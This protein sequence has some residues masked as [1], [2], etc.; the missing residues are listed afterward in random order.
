MWFC[1][2]SMMCVFVWGVCLCYVDKPLYGCPLLL[3]WEGKKVKRTFVQALR[4]CIGRTAYRGSRGIALPFLDYGTRRGWAVIVTLRPLFTPGKTRYPIC[5]GGWVGHRAG[6][7][8]KIS[9]RPGFD[10]RTVQPVVSRYTDYATRPTSWAGNCTKDLT[11]FVMPR[12]QINS[13]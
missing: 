13:L 6:Q 11:E 2:A 12:K 8:R 5:T 1:W 7:V 10:P 4:L 9:P 3:S